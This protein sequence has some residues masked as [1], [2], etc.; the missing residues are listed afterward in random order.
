MKRQLLLRGPTKVG[1]T[2]L[3]QQLATLLEQAKQGR[4]VGLPLGADYAGIC[5]QNL[6]HEVPPSTAAAS[7]AALFRE[8]VAVQ[9]HKC[10]GYEA[11]GIRSQSKATLAHA[12][13]YPRQDTVLKFGKCGVLT[14]EFDALLAKELAL[15]QNENN[16]SKTNKIFVFD[17]IRHMEMSSPYAYQSMTDLFHDPHV[18]VV[19]TVADS[20][21]G[22]ISRLQKQDSDT[23][24]LVVTKSNR[25]E[26]LHSHIVPWIRRSYREMQPNIEKQVEKEEEK[27][28]RE[29]YPV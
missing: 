3:I 12:Q 27:Q 22:I 6:W 20:N 10:I 16:T 11:I 18:L 4:K 24:V 17:E 9:T 14:H 26:L 7:A 13:W 1:K 15:L 21:W 25:N 23:E 2:T 5:V 29:E 19:A 28:E 8:D